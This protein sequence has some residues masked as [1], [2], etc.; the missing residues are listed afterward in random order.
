M[1]V[2]SDFAPLIGDRGDGIGVE[3]DVVEGI[4]KVPGNQMKATRRGLFIPIEIVVVAAVEA[5]PMQRAVIVS[6]GSIDNSPTNYFVNVHP[7]RSYLG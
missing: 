1:A 6:N 5:I 7:L 2:V 3:H 4:V